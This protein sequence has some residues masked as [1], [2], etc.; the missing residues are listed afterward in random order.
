MKIAQESLFVKLS[1]M[2]KIEKKKQFQKLLT[3]NLLVVVEYQYY[4][5]ASAF[6]FYIGRQC[7]I[8]AMK[9]TSKRTYMFLQITI[10]CKK[11]CRGITISCLDYMMY[12]M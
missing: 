10:D 9:V 5:K 6:I 2:T 12:S 4:M 8:L 7:K 11:G 3:V 1:K